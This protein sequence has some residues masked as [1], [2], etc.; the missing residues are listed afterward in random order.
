VFSVIISPILSLIIFTLGSG[1]LTTLLTVRLHLTGHGANSAGLTIALYY[2]GMVIGSFSVGQIIRR[3]GHI[4]VFAAFAS[5]LSIS[6]ILYGLSDQIWFWLILRCIGGY[7]LAGLYVAIQSWLLVIAPNEKRG[8]ILSVYMISFYAAL[9]SG[10]FLLNISDPQTLIPFCIIAMLVSASIVPLTMTRATSP[11]FE[12]ITKLSLK[13]LYIISPSGLAGS[14][15]AGGITAAIYGLMPLFVKQI[16]LSNAYVAI[17]MS[18]IIFGAM[19]IQYPIGKLSDYFNR[20]KML[21][22]ISFLTVFISI[23]LAI[24]LRFNVS[25]FIVCAFIFGGISFS[26]YPL[27]ISHTCDYLQNKN[28]IVAATQGLLLANGLGSIVGPILA[29]IFMHVLGPKG[30][31]I[32]FATISLLL[33]IFFAWRRKKRIGPLKEEQKNFVPASPTPV[34]NKLDT[35][36]H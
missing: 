15:V 35:T 2:L 3:V 8:Q 36:K 31:I 14:F 22:Y 4:R 34:P 23:L 27:S 18:A 26:L 6:S 19:F 25:I 7:C 9:A 29:P 20:R 17:I 24:S 1:L 13:Q 11:T 21:T 5:I 30:L 28:E 10:Q 33:S 32:F 12:N 16:H